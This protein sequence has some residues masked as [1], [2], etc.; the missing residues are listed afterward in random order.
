MDYLSDLI[1]GLP[2]VLSAFV[3]RRGRF[4][5]QSVQAHDA[6]HK[7]GLHPRR[8]VRHGVMM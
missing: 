6:S 4:E 8:K 7:A 3:G 2:L 1:Y 5:R